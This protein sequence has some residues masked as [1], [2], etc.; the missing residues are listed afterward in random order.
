M[1]LT[2]TLFSPRELAQQVGENARA[3]RLAQNLSRKTL[4]ERAG[5]SESTIK[6]FEATGQITLDVLVL[7]ASSLGVAQQLSGLFTQVQ[8]VS[9]DELKQS[10]R[11]RGANENRDLGR[12]AL[13]IAGVGFCPAARDLVRM[14]SSAGGWAQTPLLRAVAGAECNTVIE[15]KPEHHAA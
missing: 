12:G 15:L 2:H 3:L 7:L 14:T 11:V 8:P 4:A 6:R 1:A 5:V 9:L 13:A 10:G